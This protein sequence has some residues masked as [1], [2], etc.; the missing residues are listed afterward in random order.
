MKDAMRRDKIRRER[1][2]RTM[3]A[4]ATFEKANQTEEMDKEVRSSHQVIDII[5]FLTTHSV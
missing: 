3:A 1:Y 2:A 5:C 4:L